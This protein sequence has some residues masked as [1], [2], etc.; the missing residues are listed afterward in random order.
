M[1]KKS[2]LLVL[3]FFSFY[4]AHSQI[5]KAHLNFTKGKEYVEKNQIDSALYYF[6]LA[7][8]NYNLKGI[9]DSLLLV[10]IEIANLFI[11]KYKLDTAIVMLESALQEI[12]HQ[13]KPDSILMARVMHY[14][15]Y[16][17]LMTADF[18]RSE[19]LM[20]EVLD[21]RKRYYGISHL[22]TEKVVTN[23]GILY[24][25][26]GYLDLSLYYFLWSSEILTE[27]PGDNTNSLC[28]TYINIS[29]AYDYKGRLD[30]ALYFINKA[31]EIALKDSASMMF[32]LS[33]I[34][35][36]A[37]SLYERMDNYE[38]ANAYYTRSLAI[39]KELF[40]EGHPDIID[41]RL[42]IANLNFHRE[43][44][45]KALEL[46]RQLIQP[47]EE[48]ND[49]VRLAQLYNNISIAY[50]N[51]KDFEKALEYSF[52]SL[53]IKKQL[54]EASHY[55]LISSYS[56]LATINQ[57]YGDFEKADL[58]WMKLLELNREVYDSTSVEY[59]ENLSNVAQYLTIRMRY[60]DS[61][62][63]LYRALGINKLIYPNENLELANIYMNLAN[64]FFYTG[65]YQI[66]LD[67][68]L[69]VIELK[70]KILGEHHMSIAKL[71]QNLANI[72]IYLEEYEKAADA[73]DSCEYIHLL[74]YD[75]SS[76]NLM[77]VYEL[78]A[79]LYANLGEVEK[80]VAFYRKA[81]EMQEQKNPNDYYK[82]SMLYENLALAYYPYEPD[83][84]LLYLDKAMRMRDE[85][86][87][88]M[89]ERFHNQL[90]LKA[91]NYELKE[92]FTE[93]KAIYQ[94]DLQLL[95]SKSL[96]DIEEL[97]A[98]PDSMVHL[99]LFVDLL[100][101][102][103][104]CL[105]YEYQNTENL[106]SLLEASRLLDAHDIYGAVFLSN[107]AR[108]TDKFLFAVK[109]DYYTLLSLK[110][111][112]KL[113][114]LTGEEKYFEK[115]F[116][117]CERNKAHVLLQALASSEAKEFSGV[118]KDLIDK[119]KEL[120][121]DIA[122]Y[123]RELEEG[124]EDEWKFTYEKKLFELKLRYDSLKN[125][126]E[127]KYPAYHKLKYSTQLPSLDEISNHLSD[128]EILLSYVLG[129]SSI[130][131]F[132]I[133][134]DDWKLKKMP[135]GNG[136]AD[137]LSFY[138][139][140]LTSPNSKRFA[141]LYPGYA[142]DFFKR[143]I[144]FDEMDDK[145]KIVIIPDAELSLIP[146]EA[147][148]TKATIDSIGQYDTYPFLVK[149]YEIVYSY[150][151]SLLIH[152]KESATSVP[153]I[154][155]LNDWLAFAP[156]F[157]GELS[158]G[159]LLRTRK[160]VPIEKETAPNANKHILRSFRDQY[161]TPLPDTRKEVEAIFDIY[162][163]LD[164]KAEL[165]LKGNA[166]ES[167]FKEAASRHYKTIHIASH[168]FVNSRNSEASGL[169][170]LE[171][172]LSNEDG[173]V[174]YSELYAHELNADL[175][176]LSACESG[177]GEI[178]EGEGIIGLGRALLYA[179]AKNIVV[180]LWQVSDESTKQLMIDFYRNFLE[181]KQAYSRALRGA[182]LNLL[183]SEAYAHPFY[184]APFIL[185]GH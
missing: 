122:F 13:S 87:F 75:E 73:I 2:I 111:N 114:L 98:D 27:L 22:E 131:I 50:L 139:R 128:E 135:V 70:K 6:Q 72:Y 8:T 28:G 143:L 121:V 153:E 56:T 90:I 136:F 11:D 42:N 97:K 68:D 15:S 115:A 41:V 138:R 88:E 176:V 84:S 92:N 100:G 96:S 102:W 175:A 149:D 83:N 17:E 16:A 170:L 105:F 23:L 180:S 124:V 10:K 119:E 18:V 133:T 172:T 89:V 20:L 101:S 24:A 63:L 106:E 144:P 32:E 80:A 117:F 65:Q 79:N 125:L 148:L 166:K 169:L 57:E 146:F 164:A 151:S 178:I 142:Y 26:A 141:N 171:D 182:K 48:N 33:A 81:I 132:K 76:P 77:Q 134:K 99:Q 184:W 38:K 185:L 60:G 5:E 163:N 36:N 147:F 30:S 78:K 7:E 86:G 64:N 129:G 158:E 167:A 25:N 51:M 35:N 34:Y 47:L 14:L 61:N 104:E 160:M 21:I 93:A 174:Y 168:G 58:Y 108:N 179:G 161:I 150:S 49:W 159:Y 43:K 110:V 31:K 157:E 103:G 165:Y 113:F 109:F 4:A 152:S 156:V 19:Q 53:E 71:W 140:L 173:V 29:V 82:K 162:R 59:S 85:V 44:Y 130:Y 67:Y 54:Y 62:E 145:R 118:S 39:R 154:T 66:A 55:Q 116:Y 120:G 37:G 127:E 40:Y 52:L 126:I 155:H 91:K 69:Y 183:E 181:E 94:K 46:F 95:T 107:L 74:H 3:C 1:V 123:Q 177:L 112:H 137:S 45:A 9:R 12:P